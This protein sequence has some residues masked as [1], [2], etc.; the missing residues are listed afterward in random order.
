MTDTSDRVTFVAG[1]DA[2]ATYGQRLAAGVE[3]FRNG[4]RE[5]F[6]G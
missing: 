1:D 2:R 4:I 3:T 5:R 6:L